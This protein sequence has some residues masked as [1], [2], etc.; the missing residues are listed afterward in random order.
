MLMPPTLMVLA[1]SMKPVPNRS[2]R[3]SVPG[4][5]SPVP[6]R[7]GTICSGRPALRLMVCGDSGT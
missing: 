5:A 2:T 1:P 6:V 4:R 3:L 7:V